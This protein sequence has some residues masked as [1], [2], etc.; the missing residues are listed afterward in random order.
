VWRE[1]RRAG[2]IALQ[3]AT[4]TIPARPHLVEGVERATEMVARAEGDVIVFDASPRDEAQ[5]A[6]LED[7]YIQAREAEWKEF[8][9]ECVKLQEEVNKEIS[10]G[11]LTI[12]ELDV[13]CSTRRRPTSPT[14]A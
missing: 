14:V 7:M 13:T 9:S 8:L 3:Q 6:H 1:L 10:Q 5:A 12:A 4:W 11:K 2:A